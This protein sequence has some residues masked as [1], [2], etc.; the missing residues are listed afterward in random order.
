MWAVS[1][2]GRPG[3]WPNMGAGCRGRS[4]WST[5][6]I[7]CRGVS[8]Q[9]GI[10][11]MVSTLSTATYQRLRPHSRGRAAWSAAETDC[12]TQRPAASST[13]VMDTTRHSSAGKCEATEPRRRLGNAHAGSTFCRQSSLTAGSRE[14][15]CHRSTC[16]VD[17]FVERDGCAEGAKVVLQPCSDAALIRER[18]TRRVVDHLKRNES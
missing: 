16:L 17:D 9:P 6:D 5:A 4:S 15:V 3:L 14:D 8:N 11:A 13:R 2:S 10:T 1:A 18:Q 12:Q 7:G